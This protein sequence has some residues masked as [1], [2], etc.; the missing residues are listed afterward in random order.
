[1]RLSKGG[2][3]DAAA[4]LYYIYDYLHTLAN[5]PW[6]LAI[7]KSP[8]AMYSLQKRTRNQHAISKIQPPLHP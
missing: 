3:I 4:P 1:M 6:H 7:T 5:M 2:I 8:N